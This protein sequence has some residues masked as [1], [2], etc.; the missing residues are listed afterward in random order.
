MKSLSDVFAQFGGLAQGGGTA[1]AVDV[2]QLKKDLAE[3]ERR[4][5]FY[6]LICVG[7]I[8]FLFLA[9]VV[10]VLL[11]LNNSGAVQVALGAFGVSC[12]GLV[13]WMIALWKEKYYLAIL[14]AL[15]SNLGAEDVRKLISILRTRWLGK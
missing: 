3:V 15:A 12:A 9:L 6:L 8:V 11:S 13:R 2:G 14:L 4:N 1:P 10:V 7:M 5:R